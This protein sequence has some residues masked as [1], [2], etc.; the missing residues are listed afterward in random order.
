MTRQRVLLAR[1]QRWDL[2][3]GVAKLVILIVLLGLAWSSLIRHWF[4]AGW[5]WLP[6]AVLVA[7]FLGHDRV[8]QARRRAEHLTAYYERGLA[9]LQDRWSGGGDTGERFRD[10]EHPYASDLDLFGTG[11]LFELIC[12]ARTSMGQRCLAAWMLTP[13]GPEVVRQRQAR[14]GELRDQLNLRESVASLG[15]DLNQSVQPERLRVWAAARPQFQRLWLRWAW[16]ALSAG[17]IALL[18]YGVIT[19]QFAWLILA[20]LAEILVLGSLNRKLEPVLAERGAN[21]AGLKLFAGVVES[22]PAAVPGAAA[23]LRRLARLAD[24]IEAKDSLLGKALDFG[25]LY[26]VHL[27][28]A[29][30]SWRRRHGAQVAGWLDAVAEFEALLSLASLAYERPEDP[31]PE[32]EESAAPYVYGE[33]LGHPL[34][35][36]A[37]CVRNSVSM[38]SQTRVL[39]IS[40][41]NMSGKSTLLRT[42]GLNA[43]LAQMGAPVR[44]RRLRLSPMMLG[45]RLR[46]SDSLQLGRSGFYAEILRLRQVYDLTR[47]ALPVLFLFDEL[48]EGTNSHD[49]V[50]GGQ[51][52]LRA[53]LSR[54]TLGMITTHDLALTAIA[55]EGGA[56]VRNLHFEDQIEGGDVRFDHRLRPGVVQKSNALA[57]MRI[58]G[59]DV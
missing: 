27:A 40:G 2:Q 4:V 15:E 10:G 49:R 43:V 54:N 42:V 19:G 57:L 14:V 7:L 8:I 33:E 38:D 47:G 9:R 22:L 52:L 37:G 11:S 16:A 20:V 1:G 25:L 59:L 30:E 48:L 56:A 26:S 35:P 3:L 34:L 31:F 51:G 23:A 32:L 24:W 5:L 50:I 12:T 46:S 44:A 45:T 55:D 13:A 39:L 36:A 58:I 28:Y 29:A 53:L 41:S 18:V 6:L 17:T 21:G